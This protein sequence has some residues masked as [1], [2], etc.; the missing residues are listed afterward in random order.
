MNETSA[1]KAG[2]RPNR[3]EVV[4]LAD[5]TAVIVDMD[6]PT[7]QPPFRPQGVL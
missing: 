1:R 7:Y 4:R 5:F 3:S 2:G 6:I